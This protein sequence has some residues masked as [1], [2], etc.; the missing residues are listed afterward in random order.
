MV[1]TVVGTPHYASP[2]Q[3]TVGGRID[4]RSDIYSLGVILYRM[5]GGKPPFN[6]PSMGEVIQMQLTAEP[7]PLI[8]LRPETPPAVERLVTSMLA[9]NPARR[10]Q[11]AAEVIATLNLAFAHS[12]KDDVAPTGEITILRG[13]N[14]QERTTEEMV[15]DAPTRGTFS[16][17][18]QR[19]SRFKISALS[20]TMIGAALVAGGYGLYHYVSGADPSDS[21]REL[22]QASV[23]AE[24]TS[25]K[26][27][28]EVPTPSPSPTAAVT[29]PPGTNSSPRDRREGNPAS[30]NRSQTDNR[31]LANKHYDRA[32]ALVGQRRYRDALKEC[33]EA[34]RIDP[35]HGD[36]RRLR[37]QLSRTI[38]ILKPQ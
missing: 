37:D 29:P 18:V 28:A 21:R 27:V 17:N 23:T 24:P 16:T 26:P 11:S 31:Q 12:E 4:G 34:L 1:S 36:A 35:R 9:K 2:E 8:T 10:P 33:K 5:L 38:E 30:I 20:A 32:L 15:A 25:T 19:A 6:S 22:S 3:L 14:P 7:A 13:H